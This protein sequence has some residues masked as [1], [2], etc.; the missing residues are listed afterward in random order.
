[1][2]QRTIT[3]ILGKTGQGKTLWTKSQLKQ[4]Q[5]KIIIDS[6]DEYE[7]QESFEDIFTFGDR[8]IDSLL[9]GPLDLNYK[10]QN[11]DDFD[12][13]C[14]LVKYCKNITLII[15]EASIFLNSNSLPR[16]LENMILFGRRKEQSIFAIS[17]RP[18]LISRTLTS[19]TNRFILFNMTEPRDLEYLKSIIGSEIADEIRTLDRLEYIDY[20]CNEGFEKKKIEI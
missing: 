18:A 19:Q 16:D 20:K 6:Q 1:M 3:T 17:Q 5:R 13:I 2:E 8:L 11:F 15:E 7:A 12:K 4:L 14:N 10:I 9:G